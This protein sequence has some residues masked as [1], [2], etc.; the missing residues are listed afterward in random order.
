MYPWIFILNKNTCECLSGFCRI[1]KIGMTRQKL[2]WEGDHME[3]LCWDN[4]LHLEMWKHSSS[5][6]A[7]LCH[8]GTPTHGPAVQSRRDSS[9]LGQHFNYCCLL[10][11]VFSRWKETVHPAMPK[12][13]FFCWPDRTPLSPPVAQQ[14]ASAPSEPT[15]GSGRSRR[16]RRAG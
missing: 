10:S 11:L 9:S 5:G 15:S 12:L 3:S 2:S 14:S 7:T 1:I 16:P 8:C 13:G 4:P 6:W